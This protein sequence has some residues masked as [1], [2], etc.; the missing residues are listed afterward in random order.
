VVGK[1]YESVISHKKEKIPDTLIQ[2][3]I[4]PRFSVVGKYYESVI[5]HKKAQQAQKRKKI[6]F[7]RFVPFCGYF[8][9]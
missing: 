1:Y 3:E 8:S 7:V 5:S 4:R 6:S 9:L 2:V